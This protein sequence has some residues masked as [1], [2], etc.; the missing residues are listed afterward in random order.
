MKEN[1]NLTRHQSTL[2]TNLR[3]AILYVLK[4][5]LRKKKKSIALEAS[6][7][8]KMCRGWKWQAKGFKKNCWICKKTHLHHAVRGPLAKI[9]FTGRQQS[10]GLLTAPIPVASFSSKSTSLRTTLSSHLRSTFKPRLVCD[11]GVLYKIL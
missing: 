6:S 2:I 9:C 10:W 8:I 1:R 5:P 7:S 4:F 11:Q 3:I